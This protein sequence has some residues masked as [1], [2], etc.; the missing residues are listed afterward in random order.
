MV[1][2]AM[3]PTSEYSSVE[4]VYRAFVKGFAHH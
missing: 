2:N 3:I 4:C 1:Q